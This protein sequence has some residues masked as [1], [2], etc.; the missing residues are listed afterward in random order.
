MRGTILFLT[1]LFI[2]A[3]CA[4]AWVEQNR[5]AVMK[6]SA[7]AGNESAVSKRSTAA[8]APSTANGPADIASRP[9]EVRQ[10]IVEDNLHGVTIRDPYRYL[11][12]SNNPET[13]RY[14]TEELAYTRKV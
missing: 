1:F 9:P 10:Q 5:T 8:N 2:S 12:D 6:D 13:Q 4:L 14:V 3:I 11:E 7:S